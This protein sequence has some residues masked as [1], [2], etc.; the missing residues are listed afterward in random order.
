MRWMPRLVDKEVS[1]RGRAVEKL[2]TMPEG[3]TD[4][5]GNH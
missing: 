5:T 4:Y 3:F 1:V 2:I